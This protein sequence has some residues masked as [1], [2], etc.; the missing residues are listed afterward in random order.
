[1]KGTPMPTLL[2]NYTEILVAMLALAGLVLMASS[3]EAEMF[4]TRS[5]RGTHPLPEGYG[6]RGPVGP[7]D[8]ELAVD[9]PAAVVDAPGRRDAPYDAYP[10]DA[11]EAFRKAVDDAAGKGGGIVY[12]PPGVYRIDETVTVPANTTIHGA[13][14][15]THL[16]TTQTDGRTVFLTAGDGIRFTQFRLQG[17]TTVRMV[18]NASKGIHVTDGYKGCRIDHIEISGFGHFA[19]GVTGNGEATVEYVYDHHNTQNGYGYGVMVTGGGHATVTDSELEQNRHA[20][21]SNSAGTA[22]K[23]LYCYIHGDDDTYR[24]GALDTHP[25]MSGEIEIA[26]NFVENQRTGLSLSD[27]S[28]RIH[29]NLFR[30]VHRFCSIRAGIHNGRYIEGAEAHDMIFEDNILQNVA[31][32]YDIR[33]GRNIVIDGRPVDLPPGREDA[34]AV[35]ADERAA[36]IEEAI[37]AVGAGGIVFLPPWTYEIAEPVRVPVGVTLLGDEGATRIIVK[38]NRPAFI[39]TGDAVR[40]CRLTISRQDPADGPE[41]AGVVVRNGANC[42]ID[43]CRFDGH[44]RGGVLFLVGSGTVAQNTF[45]DCGE[46]AVVSAGAEVTVTDNDLEDGLEALV[47]KPY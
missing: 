19:V 10:P 42:R 25:G 43:R 31:V 1:M 11:S 35:A 23:C 6:P 45:R 40:L 8:V 3:A 12:I 7:S 24:V 29:H 20:I 26:H 30:N 16:Y 28:G 27:G 18:K 15:A 47:R 36:S 14:R 5:G 9:A 38:G 22:Y 44:P 41:A 46:A 39:V 2:L 21:A 13:G 37:A 17:P 34:D 32:P 33:G 4:R